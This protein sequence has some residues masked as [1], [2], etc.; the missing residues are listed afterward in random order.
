M[1]PAILRSGS[2][3][4]CASKSTLSNLAIAR[5][6]LTLIGSPEETVAQLGQLPQ[7][8]M[9]AIRRSLTATRRREREIARQI[10]QMPE[11]PDD[12]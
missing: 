3:G 1:C 6:K 10:L 8:A 11:G 7:N 2:R 9:E 12:E 5:G 4:F